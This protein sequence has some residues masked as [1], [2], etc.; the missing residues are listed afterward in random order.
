[1]SSMSRTALFHIHEPTL[2]SGSRSKLIGR[3]NDSF[4]AESF[5]IN[6]AWGD[7]PKFKSRCPSALRHR[8]G[9]ISGIGRG[10][11]T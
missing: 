11:I 6:R 10:S 4:F 1:M 7:I 5:V 9:P 8:S 3:A 2:R